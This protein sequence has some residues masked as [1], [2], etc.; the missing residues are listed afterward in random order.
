MERNRN[1]KV[2]RKRKEEGS[3][4]QTLNSVKLF[5]VNYCQSVREGKKVVLMMI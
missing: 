4:H 3:R 5:Q 2:E 1:E